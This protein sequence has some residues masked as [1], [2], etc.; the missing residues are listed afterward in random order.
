VKKASTLAVL[1]AAV[2]LTVDAGMALAQ[3]CS[4][5]S[6]CSQAVASW[7]NGNSKLDRDGDDIPC[8]KLCGKNGENMPR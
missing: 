4:S 7:K 1:A 8:E 6:N 2:A 3:T 5:F